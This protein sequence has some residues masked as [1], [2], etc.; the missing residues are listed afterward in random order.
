MDLLAIRTQF[1]KLSGRYDLVVDTVDYVD[2]G[3]DFFIQAAS[4]FLDRRADTG[5]EVAVGFYDIAV[6]D[7]FLELTACRVIEQV[8]ADDGIVREQLTEVPESEILKTFPGPLAEA[9]SGFP[10]KYSPGFY[11]VKEGTATAGFLTG[12]QTDTAKFNGIIFPPTDRILKMEVK[13]KFYST[14]LT[15]DAS[16]NYWTLNHEML[17]VW[18]ALYHLEISYRNSEGARDW[19][20]AIETS[21]FDLELD[22][23]DQEGIN[24]RQLKG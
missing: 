2:N 23:V 21:L 11:R 9:N 24:I 19:L 14:I 13:G 17:L 15:V 22:L 5:A 20:A 10:A 1:V 16:E 3:A 12:T 4:K 6:D 7:F 18:A 8:W